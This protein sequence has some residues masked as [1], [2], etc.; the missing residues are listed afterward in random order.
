MEE[1]AEVTLKAAQSHYLGTVLRL[2]P[3]A[4]VLVFNGRDGEWEAR[5]AVAKRAS[6]LTIGGKMVPAGEYSLFI[7][8][9]SPNEWTLIVSNWAA[10]Q[11]FNEASKDALAKRPPSLR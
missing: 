5:L 2:K 9:K 6:S 1:G 10:A 7:E 4:R 3:G 8:L 11:K